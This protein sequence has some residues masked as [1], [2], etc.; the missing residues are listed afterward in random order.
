[1]KSGDATGADAVALFEGGSVGVK[2][3]EREYGISRSKLYELMQSGHLP[4]SQLGRRRV[5]PR[6][7]I[8]E[9]MARYAVGL[10]KAT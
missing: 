1:M 6:R 8:A 10:P 4:Y 2:A 3:A 5:I 7:A 9:L